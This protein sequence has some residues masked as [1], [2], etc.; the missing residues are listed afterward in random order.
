MNFEALLAILSRDLKLYARN[1]GETVRPLIFFV[2]ISSLFPIALRLP[3]QTLS[4][5]APAIIWIAA[6]LAIIV[7]LDN[8]LQRDFEDG[9]LE[10]LLLS[11][12]S[13]NLLLFGKLCA[14]WLIIALPILLISPLL[15]IALNL[16]PK[17]FIGLMA[18]LSIGLPTLSLLAAIGGALTVGLRQGGLFLA[19]L[20]LPLMLPVLLFG[21]SATWA[22]SQL[23]PF[24]A[25]LA[26]LTALFLLSLLLAPL[27]MAYAI[28]VNV[29]V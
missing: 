2:M 13:L 29:E 7:S 24:I 15:G 11:P 16:P 21:V 5:F 20:V 4:E 9:S 19:L 25:E 3:P 23:L 22:A 12:Y 27:I 26:L 18:S 14:H 10:E 17:G 8:L 1:A 6:M 28:K